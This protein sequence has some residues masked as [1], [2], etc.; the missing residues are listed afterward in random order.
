MR[1]RQYLDVF[2]STLFEVPESIL[3][4]GKTLR[5]RL[6]EARGG[7][8]ETVALVASLPEVTATA[9]GGTYT[10]NLTPTVLAS[11]LTA[12]L[13]R[14]IYAHLSDGS[15]WRDTWPLVPTDTDP[16]LL[17]ALVG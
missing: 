2:R 17:P 8:P 12:H 11:L 15:G 7:N 10:I 6:S 13:G 16:D 1:P 5:C 14:T 9:V 3:G 4:T